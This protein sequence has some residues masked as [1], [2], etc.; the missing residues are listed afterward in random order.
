MYQKKKWLMVLGFLVGSVFGLG[1][2]A[3]S[4]PILGTPGESKLGS[5]NTVDDY[6]TVDW[7]VEA[8]DGTGT[9]GVLGGNTATGLYAY[10]Y[11]VEAITGNSDSTPDNFSVTTGSNGGSVVQ[12]GVLASDDINVGS[13][14]GGGIDGTLNYV[15]T[16]NSDTVNWVWFNRLASD[17][18][19]GVLWYLSTLPPTLGHG[20][21]DDSV[22]P[23]PWSTFA[24]NTTPGEKIPVPAP[25]PTTFLG[26]ALG[27]G[28]VALYV[29]RRKNQA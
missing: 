12:A 8:Y 6:V 9:Y 4:A 2:T 29:R 27:L 25:E 23:S 14:P 7:L 28:A 11:Q 13:E 16:V 22:P 5:T 15:A 1:G 10:Y 20:T 17:K 24:S 3:F 26:G 18:E 21:A 19:T